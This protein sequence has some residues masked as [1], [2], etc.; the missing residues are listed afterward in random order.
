LIPA[1]LSNP[2]K[3]TFVQLQDNPITKE[4]KQTQIVP[5]SPSEVENEMPRDKMNKSIVCIESYSDDDFE[6]LPSENIAVPT[7]SFS[8]V[9]ELDLEATQGIE[10]IFKGVFD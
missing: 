2:K 10:Q 6:V 5:L 9:D 1:T 3:A 8:Q 4:P 7:F